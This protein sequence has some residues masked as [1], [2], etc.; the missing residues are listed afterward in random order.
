ML[1]FIITASVIFDV[2]TPTRSSYTVKL[3]RDVDLDSFQQDM[4]KVKRRLSE[5]NN[6]DDMC[7]LFSSTRFQ[8]VDN[9]FLRK[10]NVVRWTGSQCSGLHL[11]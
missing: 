2:S 5:M 9:M 1:W 7:T 11:V 8:A 10:P 4:K 3:Y 6:V